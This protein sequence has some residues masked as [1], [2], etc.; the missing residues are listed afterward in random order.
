MLQYLPTYLSNNHLSS[1]PAAADG[2][3]RS[4]PRP[5]GEVVGGDLT[6]ITK[7]MIERNQEG[8]RKMK[9]KSLMMIRAVSREPEV[10]TEG[11]LTRKKKKDLGTDLDLDG[12]TEEGMKI[13]MKRIM[14]LDRQNA[15]NTT[16]GLLNG[17]MLILGL[18]NE[19]KL[20]PDRQ[21]ET[22]LIVGHL[23][24]TSL[25]LGLLKEM[26]IQGLLNAMILTLGR[27]NVKKSDLEMKLDQEMKSDL[28]TK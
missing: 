4:D 10:K 13:R 18:L 26:R 14:K 3:V 22:I 2:V 11:D 24:E 19:M 21:N 27:Q 15:M 1:I 12:L 5:E 6:M 25:M 7:R 8:G 28:E 16:Q 9:M 20:I 17:I 23:K